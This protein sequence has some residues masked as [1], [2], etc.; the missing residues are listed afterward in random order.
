MF[1]LETLAAVSLLLVASGPPDGP[2][3]VPRKPLPDRVPETEGAPPTGE[4]PEKVLETLRADLARRTGA[5]P[6][7]MKVVRAEEVVFDDGSLGC[8]RPGQAYTQATVPGYRVVLSLD[9]KEYDYRAARQGSFVLC[10]RGPPP[11]G[12]LP[13]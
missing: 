8:G 6:E 2:A 4:V 12:P 10:D 5:R 7:A 3:P 13:R 11:R 1:V 9:G